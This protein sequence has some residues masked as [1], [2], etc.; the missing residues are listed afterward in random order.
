MGL[1]G[2]SYAIFDQPALV[3][4]MLDWQMHIALEMFK[5]VLAAGVTL[6]W[7]WLW[8]DICFN[9]GPLVSPD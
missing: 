4:E 1:Q 2:I 9:K 7:V 6:E 3:E 5:K 8:E